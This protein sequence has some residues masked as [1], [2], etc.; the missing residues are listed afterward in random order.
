MVLFVGNVA[1]ELLSNRLVILACKAQEL[2]QVGDQCH[3]S[4]ILPELVVI[5]RLAVVVKLFTEFE[6]FINQM[7]TRLQRLKAGPE[8]D[9]GIDLLAKVLSQMV[10][11][12]FVQRRRLALHIRLVDQVDRALF[13]SGAETVELL[14]VV[15]EDLAA[16]YQQDLVGFLYSEK[17]LDGVCKR[18][19]IVDSVGRIK[20]VSTPNVHATNMN[21]LADSTTSSVTG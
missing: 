4:L 17:A 12:E 21:H 20:Y 6:D 9:G 15:V 8:R 13:P 18:A 11:R 2:V 3:K 5:E 14:L 10:Q 7:G 16:T 19:N 1:F